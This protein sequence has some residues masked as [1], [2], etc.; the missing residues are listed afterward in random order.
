MFDNKDE[1]LLQIRKRKQTIMEKKKYAL[2][3]PINIF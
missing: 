3:I 2:E 1:R